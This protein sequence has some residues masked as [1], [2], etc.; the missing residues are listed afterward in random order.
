MTI[1]VTGINDDPTAPGTQANTTDEDTPTSGNLLTGATDPD[2]DDLDVTLNGN[3][4]GTYGNLTVNSETGAY[5]YTPNATANALAQNATVTDEFTYTITDN[6]G[7]ALPG[8]LTITVTGTNDD[9][10]APGTQANTTDEDTPHQRQP[11][12]RGHRP[13][14]RRPRR[15]PQRQRRRHL[16]QPDRELRNRHL[17]LHPPTPPP[18]PWPKT[19]PSPMSS[20]TPSP[21][22]TAAKSQAP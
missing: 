16:R 18:T 1:T 13:R 17:H 9:P 6:N 2:G 22:T 7:G 5:T 4:V 12:H 3:G 10:T 20:P 19:P 8:T 11:A 21:T 14:R 15:H